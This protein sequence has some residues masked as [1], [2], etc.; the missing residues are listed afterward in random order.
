[1]D[2]TEA[3]GENNPICQTGPSIWPL[4]ALLCP[5]EA[6]GRSIPRRGCFVFPLQKSQQLKV[7]TVDGCDQKQV[8]A[9]LRVGVAGLCSVSWGRGWRAEGRTA[10]AATLRWA[11]FILSHQWLT[12]TVTDSWG[13][14]SKPRSCEVKPTAQLKPEPQ[15]VIAPGRKLPAAPRFRQGRG[16]G[17]A[18]LWDQWSQPRTGN[19]PHSLQCRNEEQRAVWGFVSLIWHW[20]M[21][22]LKQ[23]LEDVCW[24]SACAQRKGPEKGTWGQVPPSGQ[25]GKEAHIVQWLCHGGYLT[26]LSC[27]SRKSSLS[28]PT[29]L[30]RRAISSGCVC[31][32]EDERQQHSDGTHCSVKSKNFQV[33]SCKFPTPRA[34]EQ[35]H[36]RCLTPLPPPHWFQ[37]TAGNR[38]RWDARAQLQVLP[39]LF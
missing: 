21:E 29:A 14:P 35:D 19:F 2:S 25:L 4:W 6:E 15:C 36:S 28:S 34:D 24:G 1:M 5:E 23:N 13:T 9:A 20:L 39:L 33:Q 16:S 37:S 10:P 27:C 18:L 8:R 7:W 38:A 32:Q 17:T 31:S 22:I 30:L 11:S 3:Q 12:T 26:D